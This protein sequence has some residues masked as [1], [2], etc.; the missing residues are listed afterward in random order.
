M[1]A[2]QGGLL[3]AVVQ[4]LTMR[5]TWQFLTSAALVFALGGCAGKPAAPL[6]TVAAVDLQRYLG[7]WYEIALIPN[8]FQAVTTPDCG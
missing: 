8:R 1:G 3:G 7:A 5:T 4:F 6:P 2:A